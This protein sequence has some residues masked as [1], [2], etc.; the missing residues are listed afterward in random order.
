[1]KDIPTI[2]DIDTVYDAEEQITD[3][4]V[5][6]KNKTNKETET[7]T[8]KDLKRLITMWAGPLCDFHGDAPDLKTL[9]TISNEPT[10]LDIQKIIVNTEYL[11]EY[12]LE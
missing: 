4:E 12:V 2:R 10:F 8:E 5:I 1:M 6:W 3:L 11:K 7:E 9:M